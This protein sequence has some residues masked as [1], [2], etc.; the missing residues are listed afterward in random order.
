L[1]QKPL[2]LATLRPSDMLNCNKRGP[3]A[4]FPFF[5][6]RSRP[7]RL[8]TLAGTAAGA[9]ASDDTDHLAFPDLEE[10]VLQGPDVL[11]ILRAGQPG[12]A[13]PSRWVE[14]SSFLTNSTPGTLR[15]TL[16]LA[17]R[18]KSNH[19]VTTTTY[20]KRAA[21]VRQHLNGPNAQ[22]LGKRQG[23][24]NAILAPRTPPAIGGHFCILEVL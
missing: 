1:L 14:D 4:T 9:V 16:L 20:K 2:L 12:P 24:L 11:I 18:R 5:C 21:Q 8:G 19:A 13:V 15:H 23:T 10:N 6:V 17:I 7:D 22:C 3:S